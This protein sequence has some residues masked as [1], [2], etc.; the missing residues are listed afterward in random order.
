MIIHLED[1]LTFGE[2]FFRSDGC[3]TKRVARLREGASEK[4]V[5][6]PPR[7]VTAA[8]EAMGKEEEFSARA[9]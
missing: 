8:L 5:R 4:S 3:P 2:Y 6:P 1:I 7:G 9:P